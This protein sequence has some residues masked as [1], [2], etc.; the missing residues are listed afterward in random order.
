M[1]TFNVGTDQPDHAVRAARGALAFQRAAA[2]VVSDH[3]DWPRFR[4]GVN[5]GDA[6]VGVIGGA[7]DRGYTVIGDTVNVASRLEALAPAGS[8]AIGG[9]TL[10]ALPGA[11]VV[12]LGSVTVKGRTE[13]VDVWRLESLPD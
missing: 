5:T 9:A 3:P 10:R 12:S 2:G 4:V 11:Q 8:V 1:V 6:R 7:D 13:P